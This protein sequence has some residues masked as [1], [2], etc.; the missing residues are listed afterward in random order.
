VENRLQQVTYG[1]NTSA[2]TY[3]GDGRR[4][5]KV[6]EGTTTHFPVQYLERNV[7]SGQTQSHYYFGGK[8]V[9]TRFAQ[10]GYSDVTYLHQEHLE[11]TKVRTDSNGGTDGDRRYEPY[12]G[13]RAQTGTIG[14]GKLFT[15]QRLDGTELC[16]YNARYYDPGIGR[17]VSADPVVPDP[18][19][20]QS[21]NRYSYV[22]NNPLRYTD[23]TGECWGPLH[24][25]CV[26][27]WGFTV[28]LANTHGQV[29]A[30]DAQLQ[31]E[32]NYQAIQA[33]AQAMQ[34]AG[35]ARVQ[36]DIE[37]SEATSEQGQEIGQSASAITDEFVEQESR[38]VDLGLQA[39][40]AEVGH[41]LQHVSEG[42]AILSE[43]SEVAGAL[44][45]EGAQ[46]VQQAALFVE[47][48]CPSCAAFLSLVASII[49]SAEFFTFAFEQASFVAGQAAEITASYYYE[50]CDPDL[51]CY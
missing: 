9:A 50:Y 43:V 41:G 27:V 29:L 26:Q 34:Y 28:N 18:G 16:Y 24:G 5:K 32:G 10:P 13:V 1:A 15:G 4:M 3:D 39:Q 33:T 21:L 31:R 6:E 40:F 12:G 14:V 36:A 42:A 30:A 20:P 51:G 17:F 47:S 23:P 22:L 8:Y 44:P 48:S 7:T 19:N 2:Y 25:I 37:L 38:N 46:S 45:A 11:S 35:N 49:A